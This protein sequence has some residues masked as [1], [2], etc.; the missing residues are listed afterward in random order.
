MDTFDNINYHSDILCCY[1]K[2]FQNSTGYEFNY[3]IFCY[4]G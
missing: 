2:A 4:V 1:Q 3:Y